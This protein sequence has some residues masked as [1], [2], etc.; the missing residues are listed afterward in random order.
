L[1]AIESVVPGD[2]QLSQFQR[3]KL[4]EKGEGFE[5]RE[6]AAVEARTVPSKEVLKPK[7]SKTKISE[8]WPVYWA[9]P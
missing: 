2:E 7:I 6:H 1:A 8:L 3:A 9:G 4:L 5:A